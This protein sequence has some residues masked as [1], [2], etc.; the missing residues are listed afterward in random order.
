MRSSTSLTIVGLMLLALCGCAGPAHD[1][2]VEVPGDVDGTH[3]IDMVVATTRSAA[4]AKPGEMF[5][6]ERGNGLSFAKITVS[7]PPDAVRKVGD[8]QWPSR[9][10][11][12]P[13][14]D[15]VTREARSIDEAQETARLH[16]LLAAHAGRRV[17]VFV[18]G[19]NNRFEEAVYRLAQIA[20]DSRAPAVPYLFTWPSRGKLLAYTYDSVSSTYSRDAL[21]EVLRAL[22]RDPQVGEVSILAHSMGNW[23]TLET[24]RQ[25]SI[26][27]GGLPKKIASVMLAAPDVDVDV[28][29]TQIHTIHAPST[30][31]SLFVSQ[32]DR[33]LAVSQRFWGN[34]PRIGAV[35]PETE[36]YRDELHDAR[37]TAFDLTKLKTDDSTRHAKFAASPDVVRLIG[38]RL[39]EGQ[40]IDE[41]KSG[42]G[43]RI[44]SVAR[45]AASTL[46]SA[47]AFTVSAPF[48]V[49]D[50]RTRD[51]LGDR[52]E[53]LGNDAADTLRSTGGAVAP[54]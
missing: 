11:G 4:G 51:Q 24:L 54:R 40:Q 2:L 23:L 9:A 45:G 10:P 50:G 39:V 16:S 6:G 31:F 18:H 5:T 25:M 49:I 12:D 42:F 13:E 1:V 8:V 52:L 37:I 19:Y 38:E 33:A 32:D 34:V 36:P 53:E 35:D 29:R 28:F 20:Y 26:R 30:Q 27:N 41:D 14:R 22:T 7:L 48:A 15:F 47:A 46:G 44:G 17:L 21:E 3:K 43:D